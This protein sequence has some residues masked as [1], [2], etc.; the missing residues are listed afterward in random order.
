MKD[1]IRYSTL[2]TI[3][4]YAD[5]EA[6]AQR[7]PFEVREIP[8]NV[9][10]NE[11]ITELLTLLIGGAGTAYNNAGAFIGVGDSATAAAA[12][13]T[14]LQAST[15]KAWLAM[16]A[17]YPQVSGQTV[18]FRGVAGS[19][20]ANFDWNEFSVGNSNDDSGEN[21][22]RKVSAEGTKASGQTWTVDVAITLS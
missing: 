10:L 5:D 17:S 3:R 4:K 6:Y 15:N 19:G 2:W 11:G 16:E 22:N 20:V 12:A 8:G 1:V 21:L 18:T 9:L 13:Q 14:G 7:Q